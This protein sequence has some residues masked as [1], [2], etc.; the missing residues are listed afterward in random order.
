MVKLPA[1]IITD[2]IRIEDLGVL[3]IAIEMLFLEGARA[4]STKT[5]DR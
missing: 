4:D 2:R 3:R 1:G 5:S